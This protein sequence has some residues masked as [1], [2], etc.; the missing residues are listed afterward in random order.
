MSTDNTHNSGIVSIDIVEEMNTS[1]LDYAMSVIVSRAIPDVRDGLKPVHR[2]I[3]Y[4]MYCNGYN[5]DKPY[6]KSA[7]IV[8]EVMGRFHPHGDAAIYD[9]MARFTQDFSMRS[10]LIDGQ[11]NFGSIDN[12]PPA[13]MRYTEARLTQISESMLSDLDR[14]T[15]DF[16]LNYDNSEREP[17]VLPSSVPNILVNG[18]S[19]IAVGMATNIPCHNLGELVDA[20]LAYIDNEDITIEEILRIVPAPDFP[21][22]G[23]ISNIKEYERAARTGRGIITVRG[24]ASIVPISDSKD[25]IVITEIPYQVNKAK[26]VEKI[27]EAVKSKRIVGV[28]DL[29]DESNKDGIRVVVEL[30]RGTISNL[31]LN[32]LYSYTQ[33]QTS[34]P[35]N[36]LCL[37]NGKPETMGL[38]DIIRIFSQ[39][40]EEVIRKRI[41]FLLRKARDRA[42]VLVGMYITVQNIDKVVTTIKSSQDVRIAKEKLMKLDLNAESIKTILDLIQDRGNVIVNNMFKFTEVQAKAI[43]DMRLARLTSMESTKIEEELKYIAEHIERYLLILS[44]RDRLLKI[45]KEELLKAKELFAR[46]RYSRI[47]YKDGD[48]CDEDI[49]EKEDIVITLTMSGYIKRVSLAS[50]RSQHRGG[51]GKSGTNMK[52]E[53]VVRDIFITN[54]HA[55]ILFF[56]DRGHVYKMKA[57][58]IPAGHNNT[59]GRALINLLPLKDGENITTVMPIENKEDDTLELNIFFCTEKGT[60]RRNPLSDFLHIPSNGKIA[61]KLSEEDK[62]IGAALCDSTSDIMLASKDGRS[63]RFKVSSVREFKSRNSSGVRG[64]KLIAANKIVSMSVLKHIDV[65]TETKEIYLKIPAEQRIAEQR[66]R[67]ETLEQQDLLQLSQKAI[68]KPNDIDS[69]IFNTLIDNEEFIL[70]IT[71]NGFGK[72]TSAYEYRITDRGGVGVI[73]II[74][75]K[76][77]GKVVVSTMADEDNDIMIMTNKGIVTRTPVSTIRITGRNAQGVTLMRTTNDD[78]ITSAAIVHGNI[79]DETNDMEE[80]INP[81]D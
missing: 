62:L 73:N 25:S 10:V 41:T 48:L 32:Q 40:R 80:D 57:Y 77:N 13:A 47:E 65:D 6:K 22:G 28:S 14:E 30:K 29:R 50:Y 36:M 1:Y 58:T 39:F 12:D 43:L 46:P 38:L 7:R 35:I 11:G 42:H 8:G 5:H 9:A 79:K 45:V 44:D 76:R 53:D 19:G 69:E 20:I 63:I 70:T 52:D 55:V 60:I 61:I 24:E 3:L 72:R 37:N 67:N 27:A 66:R 81:V 2:R 56:S 64:M 49:I 31:V 78:Y 54:T 34:F 68:D 23:I 59:R 26:M 33:L 18:G 17:V 51:K 4:A 74:T 21:T 15:V 75:S 71:E 16:M